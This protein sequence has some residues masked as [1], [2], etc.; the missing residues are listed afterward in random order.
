MNRNSTEPQSEPE[1]G[2][3]EPKPAH[4][5]DDTRSRIPQRDDKGRKQSPADRPGKQPGEGEPSVG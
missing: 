2:A 1:Q 4:H 3:E 5:S